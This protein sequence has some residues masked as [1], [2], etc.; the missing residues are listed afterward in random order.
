MSCRLLALLALP[1]AVA[2]PAVAQTSFPAC[3][4]QQDLEQV[5]GSDG[6]LLPDGCRMLTVTP[7]ESPSGE[8]CMIE[9]EAPDPGVLDTL[10][11]AAVPTRWWVECADLERP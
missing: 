1:L 2:S 6:E 5:I 3:P 9:F 8:L 4:S 11:D 7:V 10:A